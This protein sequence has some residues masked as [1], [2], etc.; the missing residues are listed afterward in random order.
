MSKKIAYIISLKFAPGLLK[1]FSVL[2]KKIEKSGYE[3][4]YLLADDYKRMLNDFSNKY[5]LIKSSNSKE[6]I[7]NVMNSRELTK[8]IKN[9]MDSKQPDFVC[10]Y[11]PHPLNHIPL[12][13]AKQINNKSIRSIYLH[14]P[15]KKN[16][17]KFSVGERI[18]RGIIE[19]C[20]EFCYQYMTDAIFPSEYAKK[21]YEFKYDKKYALNKH[22]APLMLPKV[23]DEVFKSKKYFSIVGN[24]DSNRSLDEFISLIKYS[25]KVGDNSLIFKIITR[26]KIDDKISELTDNER[27]NLE[28][29]NKEF[30]TDDEISDVLKKSIA[31]LLPHKQI[32]QSGNVPTAFRWGTPI[33]ARNIEGFSQHIQNKENGM[34]LDE[35]FNSEELYNSIKYIQSNIKYMSNQALNTFDNYFSDE[36]WNEYYKWLL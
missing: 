18:Y 34:L 24:I 17:E 3:V 4:I 1:E 15:Y 14:E 22:V 11:N 12:K 5:F 27:R 29:V 13:L 19:L 8:K 25:A 2:G 28:I 26:S 21:M 23:I 30:I 7:N 20:Q 32:T 9:I 10:V 31:T 35:N 33:I 36:N 16:K 6:M